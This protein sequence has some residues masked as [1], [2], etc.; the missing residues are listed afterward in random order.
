[1]GRAARTIL[2]I[3]ARIRAISA[4]ASGACPVRE[5]ELADL[6]VG[7]GE[8]AGTVVVDDGDAEPAECRR[9]GLRVVGDDDEVGR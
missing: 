9:E 3:A 8:R 4:L 5:P 2:P 7:A 6:G 1:M